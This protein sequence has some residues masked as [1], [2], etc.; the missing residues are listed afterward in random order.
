MVVKCTVASPEVGKVAMVSVALHCLP[1]PVILLRVVYACALGWCLP[2][3]AGVLCVVQRTA[4]AG[5]GVIGTAWV[6]AALVWP[7][8]LRHG[9][10]QMLRRSSGPV[11]GV[12]GLE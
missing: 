12:V 4:W 9:L 10:P 1:L 8:H 2:L 6:D 7:G 11:C 5:S 3:S